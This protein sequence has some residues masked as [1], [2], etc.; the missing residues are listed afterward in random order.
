MKLWQKEYK[1]NEEIEK[2][3]VGIDYI[4]DK[5]LVKYDCKASAIHAE[6]LG[7]IGI[8]ADEEVKTLKKNLAD[9]AKLDSEGKFEIL[10]SHEDCHTAIEI[11]LIENAG[12]AGKKI[13]TGRSRNDQVLTAL[14]L[15]CKDKIKDITALVER[16]IENMNTFI[17]KAGD[18]PI[19][20]Y[21]HTRKAM[22][23]SAAMW[24]GAFRDA[25]KD[26]LLLLETSMKLVD[27]SP[28]G[29]G[30]GYGVSLPLD[31]KYTADKMGFARVQENPI[32][33][34]NSRGKFEGI[35]LNTLSQILYDINKLSTDMIL[36]TEPSFGYFDLPSE[37]LTGSSIMPQKKNPDVFELLRGKFH[38]IQS[39]EMQVRNTNVSL[40]SGYHRD[41]QLTKEAVMNGFDLAEAS[42]AITAFV[43]ESLEV[44]RENCKK[45]MTKEL[46]ATEMAFDLVRTGVSFR[47]AYREVAKKFVK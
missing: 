37:F 39:Y 18:V 42:I 23:S 15:Y 10:R 44:N 31:R 34:Q 41:I 2:F 43:F 19:P 16:L 6:M 32:Y 21:T 45:A 4:L 17:D 11:Y 8:L 47:E 27:Q 30:A 13:H 25:M 29:T 14:R 7:K 26:N 40:I 9:I 46:F 36:F 1:L 38:Q 24:T 12:E 20:G 22:P 35:I 33:A 28:L 3:T 5:N